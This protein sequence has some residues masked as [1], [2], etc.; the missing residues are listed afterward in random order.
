VAKRVEIGKIPIMLGSSKCV[1]NNLSHAQLATKHECPY[2][3]RGYFV[4]KG[5]E[6]VMLIQE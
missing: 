2:D 4:V 3:P 1:L 5:T 6:K